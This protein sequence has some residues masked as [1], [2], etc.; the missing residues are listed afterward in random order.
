MSAP[1]DEEFLTW[2]Y[3]QVGYPEAKNRSLTY[4]KLFRQLYTIEFVWLIRN[5]DTRLEDAKRLRLEF[6]SDAGID[7][8]DV[9]PCWLDIGCSVL[10][11]MV[12]MAR[13]LE[14][15]ADETA[16]YWFW[17]LVENLGLRRYTDA[18]KKYPHQR[19]EDIVYTV[20]FRQY[21]PHGAG[22][23]FPLRGPCVDQRNVE[24]WYQLSAYVLELTA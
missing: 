5:D 12:A 7:E 16:H 21:T 1:L 6:L 20:I 4:W 13:R 14:F 18:T 23:F 11:L 19:V 24:L 10:E 9:D 15:Q 2:L 3:S 8:R 17:N 22:G